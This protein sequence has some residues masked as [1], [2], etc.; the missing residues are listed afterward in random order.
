MLQDIKLLGS[1]AIENLG[2]G[3]Q[4]AARA[5][6]AQVM[7][8]VRTSDTQRPY[9][10]HMVVCEFLITIRAIP[11]LIQVHRS[12]E[13]FTDAPR[14]APCAD[15]RPHLQPWNVREPTS[16]NAAPTHLA[17]AKGVC[18]HLFSSAVWTLKP[19][20]KRV[21]GLN[22]LCDLYFQSPSTRSTMPCRRIC[23]PSAVFTLSTT[24]SIL[25]LLASV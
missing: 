21:A 20:Q 1:K 17:M 11:L 22:S 15:K 19:K 10:F 16:F 4:V 3:K 5:R 18:C 7:P 13:S 14:F 12:N 2:S 9:M 6:K 8:I 24:S 25:G 23:S